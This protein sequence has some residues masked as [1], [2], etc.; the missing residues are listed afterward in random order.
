MT[1]ICADNPAADLSLATAE[2]AVA[3]RRNAADHFHVSI[4]PVEIELHSDMPEA[5]EDFAILY[6]CRRRSGPTSRRAIQMEVKAC[7]RTLWGARRYAIVG[8]GN[9]LFSGLRAEEVLPYLEWG[10]NYQVIATHSEYLQL[11]AATLA[12][13]GQGIMLVGESGCGKSTLTAALAAR[14][15]GYLSDEF[16]LIDSDT[17][18]LHPFPKALCIKA[19]SFEV[20]RRLGLP[21]WRRRPY[22]KS[23]KG[24]VGYVSP[25]D[26]NV[27][28]GSFPI[29]LIVF[30]RYTGAGRSTCYPVSRSQAAFSLAANA[31]NREVLGEHLVFTL[32]EIVR[33][34]RCVTL[35]TGNLTDA[36]NQ[37]ETLV[38]DTTTQCHPNL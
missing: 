13:A 23:I 36:G 31:F 14:G 34:A 38:R 26:V 35:E 7:R 24:K 9:E 21:L 17:L 10:I 8:D 30:P 29:R 32:G 12:C 27:E 20:V 22:V 25:H 11:H 6:R 1:T 33:N 37:L 28:T 16:A 15:W 5:A 2:A 4:G 18:H 3:R 19:G